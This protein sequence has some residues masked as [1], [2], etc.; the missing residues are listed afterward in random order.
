MEIRMRNNDARAFRVAVEDR[1]IDLRHMLHTS[2]FLSALGTGF[3]HL[4][5]MFSRTY[6]RY[7]QNHQQVFT[8]FFKQLQAFASPHSVM[9]VDLVVDSLFEQLYK[10]LFLLMNPTKKLDI[11]T[12]SCMRKSLENLHPFGEMPTRVKDGLRR[13]LD[14]WRI[15][16]SSIDE[17]HSALG[18]FLNT[19]LSEQCAANLARIGDCSMCT[20]AELAKPCLNLCRNV[21]RGCLAEWAEVDQQ[22]DELAGSLGKLV[23][24]LTGPYS[25]QNAFNPLPVQLSEA[26]MTFQENGDSLSNKILA[27]CFPIEDIFGTKQLRH[28]YHVRRHVPVEEDF[29]LRGV[30]SSEEDSEYSETGRKRRA[31]WLRHVAEQADGSWK[32][33]AG[34]MLGFKEK[35]IANTGFFKSLP[36]GVCSDPQ[37]STGA[38]TKCWNGLKVDSYTLEV[39]GHGTTAQRGNPE[40]QGKRGFEYRGLFVDERLKLGMLSARVKTA[41]GI[42]DDPLLNPEKRHR[43]VDE[44]TDEDGV[45]GSGDDKD[46]AARDKNLAT[47]ALEHT[48]SAY[49]IKYHISLLFSVFLFSLFLS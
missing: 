24:G 4:D 43:L 36:D 41:A 5:T 45:E 42:K 15:F 33:L 1:V 26:I 7:Y 21:A 10:T 20:Q 19:T 29:E 3:T 31:V 40:F 38:N 6:G 46:P 17:A 8:S 16:L 48:S 47:N 13:A 11:T 39:N 35:A 44:E 22:W 28:V 49:S 34:L 27:N 12:W 25:L 14:G 37:F 18:S 32:L 9:P 30:R 2:N 23:D